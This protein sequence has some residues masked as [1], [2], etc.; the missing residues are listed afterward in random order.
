MHV[1]CCEKAL[2]QTIVG[3]KSEFDN[4][5]EEATQLGDVG[6]PAVVSCQQLHARYETICRT[7]EVRSSA[8]L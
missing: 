8:L 3:R 6:T 2:Y 7:T 5:V 4:V 1:D